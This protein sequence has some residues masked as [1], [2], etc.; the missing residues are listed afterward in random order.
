M[1]NSRVESKRVQNWQTIASLVAIFALLILSSYLVLWRESN[2]NIFIAGAC[3]V[4]FAAGIFLS[5]DRIV[6]IY[7]AFGFT[8]ARWAISAIATRQL[9]PVVAT[10][11]FLGVPSMMILYDLRRRRRKRIVS[12]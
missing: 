2:R 12:Q 5:H 1:D 4:L 7:A 9:T 6:A 10:I 11:C 8:G 3:G